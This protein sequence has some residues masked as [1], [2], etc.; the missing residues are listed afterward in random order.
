MK[1]LLFLILSVVF[2]IPANSQRRKPAET[3][4][5]FTKAEERLAGHLQRLKLEE[6][7]LVANIPFRNIGP[8]VFG[9]RVVD[10]DVNQ[11]DPTIFYV[12]YAS[13]GL[14][15]TINNGNTLFPVFDQQAVMT[16]GDIAV[17]WKHGETIWVGT[18]E[19]NSSRSSYSGT[20]IYKSTDKGETWEYMGLGESHHIGRIIIH[21][22]NPNT[23]WVAAMGHLYSPNKERGMYKTTDGGKTWNHTLYVNEN[24]GA[25]DLIIDPTNPNILY[26][27]MWH[28]ER[29]AWNFTESGEGSGIYKSTDGGETWKLISGE[30][31][32]F[33]TGKGVGRIG[34]DIYPGNPQI[35]Y[36]FLDN[37]NDDP[38][39][40]PEV[41]EGKL[42]NDALR[43]MSKEQFL[44]LDDKVIEEFL[45]ENRFPREYS[46]QAVKNMISEAKIKPVALVE[47]IEDENTLMFGQPIVEAE[48][49]RSHDGG[50]SWRRTH[51]TPIKGL[52]HT[53]GY[54]FGEIRV[55][56]FSSEEIYIM[57][58]PKLVSKDGG[59]TFRRSDGPN[60]HADHHA[61]WLNPNREGHMINGNDGGINI[62]YDAGETWY[63]VNTVPVAQFYSVN[64]DMAKPYNVYGGTQDNGTWYGSNTYD[65]ATAWHRDG[66]DT[67]IRIGGGDGMQVEIDTRE[68]NLVYLGSQF[69]NYFRLNKST[70]ERL[71]IKPRHNLGERPLRFNWQTPIHLS[72]HNQDILYYG[73]NKFHRSLNR[74]EN[75][76]T[77]SGDLTKGGKPGNV[78]YGTLT[79]IHESPVK[80]GLIYVG[81]DCGLVHMTPDGGNTWKNISGSL[82][83]D[84]W[85]SRVIASMYD[86]ATVYVTLNGYRWDNFTPYVFVSNNYGQTWRRIGTDLPLE[87][88]NVLKED[89][90]NPDILYVGTDH[91]IYVS[92]NKGKNFM[93]MKKGFPNAPVHDLVIHPRDNDLVLGTHGR[94]FY[95]A[96]VEHLQQ[97][98]PDIILKP[99]YLFQMEPINHNVRWGSSWGQWSTPFEPTIDIPVYVSSQGEVLL[100]IFS[101]GGLLLNE[102]VTDID[103]GINYVPYNLSLKEE[104]KEDYEKELS[105]R[106]KKEIKLEKAGNKQIYLV[107]GKYKIELIRGDEKASV[108]FD[109]K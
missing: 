66:R 77:L 47:Y 78:S 95:V 36:A 57:G 76:E 38:D 74:G 97:L 6:N 75:L 107:K 4:P 59:K 2:L 58:V 72:R 62:T 96:S 93:A 87:P 15:K 83:K 24:T 3:F 56:P 9:G 105:N 68:N 17:D 25:I 61:M 90:K 52:V 40:I 8:V 100:K 31:S 14:W 67:Y 27:T 98:T 89:P 49:Y 64:V 101:E 10:L 16:I 108:I 22:E 21:P 28:R 11:E 5:S 51:D 73:S 84:L 18:G 69:G 13:G 88:V 99:V 55:S 29:R 60:V 7:S 43:T 23:I 85:V 41:K 53:Y 106:H 65:P 33:P 30:E 91:G 32:G 48:V 12:A 103:K 80:F 35:I 34:L 94:S 19:N 50:Q 44:L 82:P 92:L 102:I 109:I 71:P 26:S 81:S 37:L 54:Y 42:T 39:Y 104:I 20:G 1:K 70:G 86:E 79:T 45:S 63:H 46:L